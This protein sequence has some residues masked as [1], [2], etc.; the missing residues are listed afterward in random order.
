MRV[1]DAYGCKVDAFG[2]QPG[3]WGG[4]PSHARGPSSALEGQGGMAVA[5]LSACRGGTVAAPLSSA[6]AACVMEASLWVATINHVALG[7]DAG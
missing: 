2:L 1:T 7:L 6:P 5:V 4:Q 3:P